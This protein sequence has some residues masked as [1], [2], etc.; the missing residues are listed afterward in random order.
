MEPAQA[1]AP[2]RLAL[3]AK[4]AKPCM[5]AKAVEIKREHF[6]RIL[7]NPLTAHCSVF[8]HRNYTNW[9]GQARCVHIWKYLSCN[10]MRYED[11]FFSTIVAL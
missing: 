4:H 1:N 2:R 3:L 7:E 9:T 11:T 10:S 5:A 8:V 6:C